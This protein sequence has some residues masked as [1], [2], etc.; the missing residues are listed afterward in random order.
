[1]RSPLLAL[2]LLAC[3]LTPGAR[4]ETLSLHQALVLGIAGNYDLRSAG[5]DVTRADAGVLG[6]EGHFDVSAE[7]GIGV[8]RSET[9]AASVLADAA[10]FS[11]DTASAEAALGKRFASGLQT[12]LS[13]VGERSEGDLLVDRLDPA[14]RTSLVL[15]FTQPLL[16]DLG[17]EINTADLEIA[18]TRR[19]QAALGYLAS[20]EQ[21]AGEIELA[22]LALAEAEAGQR[23]AVLAR[24][25][26]DELLAGNRRK[27]AAGLVPV[28]EVNEADS[29]LAGRQENLLLA[30]QQLTLA[31]S[32][33]LELID[34]SGAPLP[35]QWQTQLPEVADGAAM[36]LET[37]LAT[38]FA[39]RPDLRQARL[40]LAVRRL[41]LVYADNQQLPRLDLEA[42]LGVNGLAGD[43]DGGRYAG[44]WNDSLSRAMDGDGSSW[45]AGL[46]LSMPLQNRAARAQYRDAAAQDKQALYRLRRIEVAA[47]AAIRAAHATLALGRE[48]V[49]VARRFAA[50]AQTTYEQ[51]NRRLQEGLSDT[52]RVLTFQNALV[53]AK[54][55]EVAAQA[56][57]FRAQAALLQAMGSH[58]EHYAIVAALPPEGALP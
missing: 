22:Y 38:G 39:R 3:W 47:E 42:S 40:E 54:I 29:A 19:Q 4:A 8:R 55:R 36:A 49:A 23:Y 1:M 48:R 27:L 11:S 21:L 31:R 13:L 7:L 12:R 28:T 33:L 45:Y 14:Y 10:A 37:A 32:R 35:A 16:K 41:A 9:P 57:Y 53:A 6:A 24:D 18:R 25:L 50:L 15:D 34:Q 43:A 30:E 58:L 51:E 17:V 20:A 5:L 26:A 52:F 46:R 44:G 56:D 2:I